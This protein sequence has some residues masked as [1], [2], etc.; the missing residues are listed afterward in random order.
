MMITRSNRRRGAPDQIFVSAGEWI[1][2]ARINRDTVPHAMPSRLGEI[3]VDHAGAGKEVV[4]TCPAVP[5]LMRVNRSMLSILY[6][7]ST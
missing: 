4:Y 5:C 1:E 2:G 3:D 7:A 6:S